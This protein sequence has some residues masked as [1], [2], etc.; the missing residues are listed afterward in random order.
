M[1]PSYTF[2][3]VVL[4]NCR[5]C[6]PIIIF[7]FEVLCRAHLWNTL[8]DL[9]LVRLHEDK[10][11]LYTSIWSFY[12]FYN[13]DRNDVNLRSHVYSLWGEENKQE[14]NN[15]FSSSSIMRDILVSSCLY[16][17]K[18]LPQAILTTYLSLLLVIFTTRNFVFINL[19]TFCHKHPY[20]Q[21]YLLWTDPRE[22]ITSSQTYYRHILTSVYLYSRHKTDQRENTGI[23][24][25]SLEAVASTMCIL[26]QNLDHFDMF[27]FF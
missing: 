25:D 8:L 6:G 26:Q 9:Y 4:E 13:S 21:L 22:T 7:T 19:I 10:V 17:N 20:L 27:F 24:F 23:I 5:S 15:F 3:K 2:R 18:S 12:Y 1:C 11:I 16:T 14:S